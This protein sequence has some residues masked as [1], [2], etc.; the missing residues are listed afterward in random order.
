MY[1]CA[2]YV[3]IAQALLTSVC[4]S[5]TDGKC[6]CVKIISIPQYP[7]RDYCMH[8][9]M[10]LVQWRKCIEFLTHTVY[11]YMYVEACKYSVSAIP[12]HGVGL[13]SKGCSLWCSLTLDDVQLQEDVQIILLCGNV[14]QWFGLIIECYKSIYI[15]GLSATLASHK[16]WKHSVYRNMR[17]G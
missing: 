9:L 16:P 3:S 10:C 2:V 4:M 7:G 6:L 15:Q 13:S 8:S 12:I 11:M 14:S 1:G 5:S 17:N